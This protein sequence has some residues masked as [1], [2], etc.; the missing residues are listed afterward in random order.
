MKKLLLLCM[1]CS[2]VM[3]TA[4]Q[5]KFEKQWWAKPMVGLNV[6]T[7]RDTGDDAQADIKL[8]LAAGLEAGCR[9]SEYIGGSAGIIYSRQGCKVNPVTDSGTYQLDYLNFPFLFNLYLTDEL[10]FNIGVQAG[11]NL[12]ARMEVDTSSYGMKG[13][14][15]IDMKDGVNDWYFS[16]P[17]GVSF[18]AENGLS[19]DLRYSW[20]LSEV[21]KDQ[22][23]L[24]GKTIKNT[25]NR[26]RHSLV[27]LT[28]GYRFEL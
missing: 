3:A 17:I 22:M 28:L 10:S 18:A 19:L 4:Q 6:S 20:G 11:F 26:G 25:S 16:L 2:T 24:M 7:L 8:G 13:D 27:M 5:A 12:K 9:L 23:T 15:G 1:L 21:E 14:V